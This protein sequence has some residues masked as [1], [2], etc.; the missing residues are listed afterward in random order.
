[1]HPADSNVSR[2]QFLAQAAAS[3]AGK[4]KRLVIDTHLEVWT[5]NPKF[6]FHHPEHPDEKPEISATIENEV[7]EMRNSG[8]RYAVLINPRYYGWDNS[9]ISYSLHKY[10]DLFVAHGLIN[11]EDPKVADRL[12]YW[13]KEHGFQGMRFSPLYHP[14]STWLNSKAHYPLWHEAERLGAV[15]NF[16]ILPHQMPMLEDMAGRFPGVK[17]V[18]DHLGEPDLRSPDPWTNFRKMFRLKKFLQVW[19]SASEPYEISLESFPY[20]DTWPFFKAVYE[21]F[22]GKQLIWGTGYPRPRWELPMEK[23]LAFVDSVLDF[24]TS[25]DRKLIL[26]ENALRI[27]KFP[28]DE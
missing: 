1:M 23:E 19:I 12:R 16:Y 21:E 7:E 2:R 14:N 10:P 4:S 13:V 24:Y 5:I 15:F 25:E 9:Y 26:G 20:R 11:P 6:P 8:L 22:G 27:W 17:V 3:L 28:K 18:V